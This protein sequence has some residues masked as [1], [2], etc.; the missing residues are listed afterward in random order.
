LPGFTSNH[1]Y[2]FT[3]DTE[4]YWRAVVERIQLLRPQVATPLIVIPAAFEDNFMHP[5]PN[6]T[7]II[8][9]VPGSP[10]RAAGLLPG[11]VVRRVGQFEVA[12]R[13]QLQSVLLLC[14]APLD[15][16]VSRAG[17]E[18]TCRIDASCTTTFPYPGHVIGK[19]VFPFGLV[20]SYSL[21]E[22]DIRTIES[23]VETLD[24]R[25]AWILTSRL[26]YP[27]AEAML[28]NAAPDVVDLLELVVV[29]NDYLGGNI[30]VMDMATIGDIARA[31]EQRLADEPGPD[32]LFLPLTGFNAHGRDL[33]GRHWGD[34]A[35]WFG[36]PVCP[37]DGTKQ[38]L[39]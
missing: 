17:A 22:T 19:Y 35:R 25:R 4:P 33:A 24:A 38:F 37:L 39:F 13:S 5:D 36:I 30:R 15:L 2:E 7:R 3:F 10:A 18:L 14:N 34:L 31:V 32:L 9:T 27:A 6:E 8:G 21:S 20:C 23:T 12:T 16:R 11:D 28:R 26:M 1:P 29:D